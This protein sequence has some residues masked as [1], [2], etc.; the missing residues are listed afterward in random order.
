MSVFQLMCFHDMLWTLTGTCIPMTV[1]TFEIQYSCWMSAPVD[2]W[3]WSVCQLLTFPDMWTTMQ[4][5]SHTFIFLQ[6][7]TLLTPILHCA[8]FDSHCDTLSSSDIASQTN[9][10][11]FRVWFQ[12][13]QLCQAISEGSNIG[14]ISHISL[15]QAEL[16]ALLSSN[17]VPATT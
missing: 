7:I 4:R 10:F 5:Y 12:P 3:L 13:C 2:T 1:C 16:T 8:G 15:M 11:R 17:H 14:S 9:S 6:I